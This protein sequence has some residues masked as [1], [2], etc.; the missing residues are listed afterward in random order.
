MTATSA[1]KEKTDKMTTCVTLAGSWGN[2]VGAILGRC[3]FALLLGHCSTTVHDGSIDSN[4]IH[5]YE[6]YERWE[7]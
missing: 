5:R 1:T 7:S 3:C 4:V 6:R 2:G